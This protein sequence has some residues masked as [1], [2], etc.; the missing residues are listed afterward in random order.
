MFPEAKDSTDAQETHNIMFYARKENE[1]DLRVCYLKQ[2]T[3]S[4]LRAVIERRFCLKSFD[5]RQE[6]KVNDEMRGVRIDDDE[7]FKN[8]FENTTQQG[9][10]VVVVVVEKRYDSDGKHG[11]ISSGDVV[12]ESVESVELKS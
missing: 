12:M 1:T 11:Y 8:I 4:A 10:V 9:R 6:V 7:D 5:L 2:F 3:L